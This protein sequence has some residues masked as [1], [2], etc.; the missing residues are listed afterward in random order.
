MTNRPIPPL[1]LRVSAVWTISANTVFALSQ[2]LL[3][4]LLAKYLDAQAVGRFALALAVSAPVVLFANMQLRSVLGA[5]SGRKVPLETYLRTRAL[6]TA[7]AVAVLGA[8]ASLWPW[9]VARVILVVTAMKAVESGIDIMQGLFQ[10]MDR[11]DII[12]RSRLLRALGSVAGMSVGL[13]TARSLDVGL[14]LVLLSWLLVGLFYDLPRFR[15]W[16]YSHAA[17]GA[18]SGMARRCWELG[19]RA[20]PLGAAAALGSLGV[21]VPRL[22]LERSYDE[23]ELGL[24]A[25]LA[26]LIVVGALLTDSVSEA[27]LPRLARWFQEGAQKQFERLLRNLLV[28]GLAVGAAGILVAATLG[29]SLLRLLY[30]EEFVR[31]DVLVWVM[32]AAAFSYV[33]SPLNAALIAAGQF[34]AQLWA[35]ASV[36]CVLIAFSLILIPG[37]GSLGAAKA[38][39]VGGLAQVLVTGGLAAALVIGGG[40]RRVSVGGPG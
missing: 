27:A 28:L 17:D 26:Y 10:N 40:R 4:V 13:S 18:S 15:R 12:A 21:T 2:W 37:G 29:P 7:G 1:G 34:R 20:L 33:A 16:R 35:S 23:R 39:A 3:L 22:V 31:R 6:S 8:L 9:P 38:Q 24:Y 14:S 36:L 30:S 11:M 5:D 19:R 32:I 25:A